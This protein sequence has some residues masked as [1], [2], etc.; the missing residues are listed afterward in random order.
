M[1][2][3][4]LL[5]TLSNFLWSNLEMVMATCKNMRDK[6]SLYPKV[7]DPRNI[8]DKDRLYTSWTQEG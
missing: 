7:L 5:M 2:T 3:H 4:E 6:D 1:E 8:K